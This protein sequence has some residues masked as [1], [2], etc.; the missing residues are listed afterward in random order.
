LDKAI[1]I[2]EIGVDTGVR[3]CY[4]SAHD[5]DGEKRMPIVLVTQFI[6]NGD[7]SKAEEFGVVEFMTQVEHKPE[8]TSKEYN[9]GMGIDIKKAMSQ[10]IQGID[11]ILVTPSQMANVYVGQLLEMGYHKI[12]KWDNRNKNY[13]LHN[14]LI[15]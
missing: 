11:F 8:P 10:Y 15:N 12:L 3:L 4:N 14:L 6:S 9:L 1:S 7:F 2:I 5:D 13:R